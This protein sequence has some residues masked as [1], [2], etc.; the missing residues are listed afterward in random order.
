VADVR[1]VTWMSRPCIELSSPPASVVVAPERGGRIAS[2]R[3]RFGREWLAQ[4]EPA[5]WL[6][7]MQ[8]D[9][10]V[11]SDMAGWDECAPTVVA[12]TSVG[13]PYPDHGDVW[14]REWRVVDAGSDA[15]TTACRGTWFS[16]RRTIRATDTGIRLNYRADSHAAVDRPFL[17]A[18]HPQLRAPAGST[19][20]LPGEV[21][22]VVDAIG[23]AGGR[24][25]LTAE[26]LAI[27][28][29]PDGGCRKLYPTPE[30]RLGAATLLH[31]DGARLDLRWDRTVAPWVGVWMDRR[32]YAREDVIALEPSTGWYDDA[33]RAAANGTC[34]W[35]RPG[36]PLEW[37]VE[38][39]LVPGAAT[40]S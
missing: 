28:S 32:A 38:V 14:Q 25:A 21:T 23:D 33:S 1:P 12:T 3:D 19:V 36:V 39:S 26:L 24:M 29:L 20:L 6:A 27:G 35:L 31:P 40:N 11:S 30:V 15:L 5:T 2:L 22:D 34:T 16:L 9:D 13:V 4:P 18:L 7:E 10:F 37:W 17:W 8:R